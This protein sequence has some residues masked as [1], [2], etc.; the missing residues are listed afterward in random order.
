MQ[1]NYPHNMK[2]NTLG[3]GADGPGGW[4]GPPQWGLCYAMHLSNSHPPDAFMAAVVWEA[5]AY[6]ARD[7][8]VPA[9]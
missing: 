6:Q 2:N 1:N 5:G 7:H 8:N 3:Q 9:I 4:E